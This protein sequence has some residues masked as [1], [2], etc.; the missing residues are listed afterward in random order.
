MLIFLYIMYGLL[1]I[2]VDIEYEKLLRSYKI[3]QLNDN[4][5]KNNSKK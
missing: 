1:I 2:S 5:I 3:K 4:I